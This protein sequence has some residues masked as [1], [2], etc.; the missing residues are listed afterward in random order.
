MLAEHHIF[1]TPVVA[2]GPKLGTCCFL[3]IFVSINSGK[4]AQTLVYSQLSK[5]MCEKSWRENFSILHELSGRH[6]N[7][8]CLWIVLKDPVWWIESVLSNSL[9]FDENSSNSFKRSDSQM[10]EWGWYN[11]P[12]TDRFNRGVPILSTSMFAYFQHSRQRCFC[13]KKCFGF[14]HFPGARC[15]GWDDKTH[16][17]DVR[18]ASS[19]GPFEG[20]HY[21]PWII[22]Q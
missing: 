5:S 6:L 9:S 14:R 17:G 2:R 22:Y 8:L 18:C 16:E 3:V 21:D 7:P 12:R 15:S 20:G 11:L 13:P 1:S 19:G 10:T 4:I